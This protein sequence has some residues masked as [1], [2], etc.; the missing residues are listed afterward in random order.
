MLTNRIKS[1]FKQ[2]KSV[3]LIKELDDMGTLVHFAPDQVILRTGQAIE[4][5]PLLLSGSV[6]VSRL[7]DDGKEM[8]LYF[9]QSGETC[10]MTLTS[11]LKKE[12]S[13][14]RATSLTDVDILLIPAARVLFLMKRFPKWNEFLLQSFRTKLDDVILSFER[15]AFLQLEDQ[16]VDYLTELALFKGSKVFNMSH[17]DLANDLATS[18]VVVSRLLKKLERRGTVALGRAKITLL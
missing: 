12:C 13:R 10:A 1:S 16:I 3:G 7:T 17:Q 15:M 4:F 18:R 11:A 9:I 2:F 5:I 6:K 14:V 8:F